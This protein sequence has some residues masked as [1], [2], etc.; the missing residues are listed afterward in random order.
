MQIRIDSGKVLVMMNDGMC[1]GLESHIARLDAVLIELVQNWQDYYNNTSSLE[2]EFGE[3]CTMLESKIT[4][5]LDVA[6]PELSI[7]DLGEL[8]TIEFQAVDQDRKFAI[9]PDEWGGEKVVDQDDVPLFDLA[10]LI[11]TL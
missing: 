6:Y 1:T 9:I 4:E 11:D 10:A 5:Y 2:E 7:D 3:V 8:D